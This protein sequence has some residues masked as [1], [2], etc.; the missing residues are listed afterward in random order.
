MWPFNKKEDELAS[1][2]RELGL[3]ES[4]LSENRLGL[5]ERPEEPPLKT[6]LDSSFDARS[7]YDAQKQVPQQQPQQQ[8]EMQIV[9]AKLDTIKAM[10]DLINQRINTIERNVEEKQK[11]QQRPW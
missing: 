6:G 3:S 10:L 1:F 4:K 7:A 9:L 2:E 11:P 8:N 5:E